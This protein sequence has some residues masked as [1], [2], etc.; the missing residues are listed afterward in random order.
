M[1]QK[2]AGWFHAV[3]KLISPAGS[4]VCGATQ[5]SLR[6]WPSIGLFRVWVPLVGE[7]KLPRLAFP[8][9]VFHLQSRTRAATGIGQRTSFSLHQRVKVMA[10]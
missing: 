4:A 1:K 5:F 10:S 7:G 8:C 9:L 2:F 6:S 3:R